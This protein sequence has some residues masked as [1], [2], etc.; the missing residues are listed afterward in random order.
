[1]VDLV[2]PQAGEIISDPAAGTLGFITRADA[3]IKNATG[4]PVRPPE[5]RAGVPAPRGL[6][7]RRA[8][9]RHPPPGPDER[10]A[11]RHRLRDRARATRCRRPARRLPKSDLILTNPPFGTK[12]GGGGPTRDDFTFP[13]SNKQL[14]FLQHIYRTSSPAAAPRWCCPTTCSSRTARAPR[15]AAD[16]MDKCD[17]HTILR[18]PTGIF[19]AQGVKTNVLFFPKG[20][21]N[22]DTGNTEA[23]WVYDLRTN[24]PSSAN[25][26]RSRARPAALRRGLRK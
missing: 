17:L 12:K 3:Y 15:S 14:A 18:L 11:A 19:Y 10:A 23:V 26:P 25:A 2:K 20:A 22:K 13:T 8:G 5:A 4:R 24:M 6:L 7:R 9:A 16:L 1:M 21:A